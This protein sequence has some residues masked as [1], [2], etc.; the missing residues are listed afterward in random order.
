MLTL[1]FWFRKHI[2]D[3]HSEQVA[4][5]LTRAPLPYPVLHLRRRPASLFDYEY[6]DFEVVGYEHHPAIKAPVAV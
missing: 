3:N 4:L 5:Q 1:L 2:Y 6:D